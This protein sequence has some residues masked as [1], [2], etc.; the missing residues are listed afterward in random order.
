[1]TALRSFEA[2]GRHLSFTRAAE[3]LFVSQA[4]ISRQI[5]DL[6]ETL[7]HALF[8]RHHRSVILTERGTVLLRLL[9]ASFDGIGRALD[10]LQAKPAETILRI[11]VEP[12][13]AA[14]WLVP[15]LDQFRRQYPDID[16][17]LDADPRL[18]D[19]KPGKVE[20]AV[21]WSAAAN[22]WPNVQ[23][24]HLADIAVSPVLSPSLLASG[25]AL[26]APAD[27]LAYPL[28]HEANRNGWHRWFQAAGLAPIPVTRG[29]L[30]EDTILVL[31]AAIRG[32]G[33]ALVDNLLA[34]DELAKHQLMKPFD[35]AVPSG[36]YWLV[37]PDFG[38]LSHAARAFAV[39]IKSEI[40]D[41]ALPNA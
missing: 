24:A 30:F 13:L 27:L 41:H 11:S 4:A 18:A 26:R 22:A 37:A 33:V 10:D 2:A 39:W 23:A 32:H 34:A 12:S 15:R 17:A 29:P 40:N 1:L 20:L 38:R 19:F 3:E 7:G 16:V 5:R 6:E 9:S 35:I 14:G 28:L 8:E 21:R 31:Q 36:A 25:A